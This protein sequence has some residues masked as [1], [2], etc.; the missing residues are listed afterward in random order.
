M[1]KIKLL[2]LAAMAV[3]GLGSCSNDGND[4]QKPAGDARLTVK[5]SG[6]NVVRSRAAQD[7]ATEG[8][9]TLI[10]DQSYIFVADVD[11]HI[12]QAVE[13]DPATAVDP[14]PGQ[15]LTEPVAVGSTVYIV[16]N[17]PSGDVAS[18]LGKSTLAE[19]KNFVSAI[20]T[21]Q[22]GY[23]S[24]SM[25]NVEGTEEEV[26]GTGNVTL[27]VEIEPLVA[28]LE[29]AGLQ[30]VEDA[31]G[32]EITAFDVTGV[33][34]DDYF[35]SFT[36]TGAASGTILSLV[37]AMAVEDAVPNDVLANWGMKDIVASCSAD[38]NMVAALED[39]VWAYNV[40]ASGLPRLIVRLDNIVYT[41]ASG[42]TGISLS[43]P[44]FLTVDGYTGVTEF[45]RGEVYR[46]G[47]V[48]ES[49]DS[50]FQFNFSHLGATP[51]EES[52]SLTVVVEVQPW[53]VTDYEPIL[54]P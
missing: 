1:R 30:A 38:A 19:V 18:V 42:T 24:P 33:F 43:G 11:G 27:T 4:P 44:R 8:A 25:A 48:D 52:V 12:V 53:N 14:A 22:G 10:G 20:S 13:I 15:E 21:Q 46:V 49:G 9:L 23:E 31:A 28:R 32:N 35:P 37:E 41:S 3:V 36:Y 26:T 2:A 34:V 39:Q 40:V 50:N 16:A 51:N 54:R 17:I 7:P 45:E 5:L 29:L 47:A 6:V